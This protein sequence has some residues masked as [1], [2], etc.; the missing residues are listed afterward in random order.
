MLWLSPI[1]S[2]RVLGVF[3]RV[4]I[5]SLDFSHWVFED[6][7]HSTRCSIAQGQVLQYKYM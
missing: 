5:I 2:D 3:T 7:F 6:Y 4:F 1:F